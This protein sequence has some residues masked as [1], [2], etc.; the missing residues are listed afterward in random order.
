M[1]CSRPMQVL[2]MVCTEQPMVILPFQCQ[3]TFLSC[4]LLSSFISF[5]QKL[6]MFMCLLVLHGTSER[7]TIDIC[8]QTTGMDLP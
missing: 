1:Q 6:A 2:C 8:G 7:E 4:L 5:S 3:K